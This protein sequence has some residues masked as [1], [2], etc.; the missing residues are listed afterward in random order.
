MVA[1]AEDRVG[2]RIAADYHE[3]AAGK[4]EAVQAVVIEF[5]RHQL[6][7]IG[8]ASTHR[9]ISWRVDKLPRDVARLFGSDFICEQHH[10]G[11]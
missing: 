11:Q 8:G 3:A 5:G 7:R 2:A 10:Y 4:V 9:D 6:L 1:I